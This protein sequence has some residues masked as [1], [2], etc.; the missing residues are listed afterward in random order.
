LHFQYIYRASVLLFFVLY[1]SAA[2]EETE[3]KTS[4]NYS[5]IDMIMEYYIDSVDN[6]V[7]PDTLQPEKT[8]QQSGNILG[9]IDVVGFNNLTM[10]NGEY[11]IPGKAED[12]A[13]IA[14]D[15]WETADGW[16]RGIDEL[17]EAVQVTPNN[18][19]ITASMNIYL[20]WHESTLKTRTICTP[21]GCHPVVW[22]QKDYHTETA[23]FT[24]TDLV[25][26]TFTP[27]NLNTSFLEVVVY[28]NSVSPKTTIKV[29]NIPENVLNINYTYDNESVIHYFGTSRQEYTD[30]NV[31]YM[32][33]QSADIWKGGLG[34]GGN[35]TRVGDMVCL[36]TNNFSA[37]NLTVSLS[38][39]YNTSEINNITVHEVQWHGLED[40]FSSLF[41]LFITVVCIFMT[42][43]I[44]Q[45]RGLLWQN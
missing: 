43:I 44:Y 9:W 36:K 2:A 17:S 15:K 34:D 10:I 18:T 3:D 28:N 24:D 27:L 4:E 45:F 25:P 19:T 29:C 39:P 14:Y 6:L 33:I 23:I 35:L 11:Y 32:F 37:A 40:T 20:K 5:I 1:S 22:I 42:G 38:D 41:W 31:P 13:I 21:F 8:V 30:K 26:A 12:H 7:Y 16:N